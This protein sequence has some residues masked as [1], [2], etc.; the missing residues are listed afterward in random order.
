M[1]T[2]LAAGTETDPLISKSYTDGTYRTALKNSISTSLKETTKTPLARLDTLQDHVGYSFAEN[3]TRV[4]L[5]P[6]DTLSLKPGSSFMLTSGSAVI[7]YGSGTVINVSNGSIVRSGSTLTRNQRYMCMEGTIA[8]MKNERAAAGYVDSYYKITSS[9]ITLFVERLYTTVLKRPSDSS[10]LI[11]WIDQIKSGRMTPAQVASSFYASPE[12]LRQSVTDEDFV[13]RLYRSLLNRAPDSSGR[14]SW[15]NHLQ[16]GMTRNEVLGH[17]LNSPEF[18]KLCAGYN[19]THDST[20]PA[21]GT[22]VFITRLYA[23]VLNRQPDTSGYH[24]WLNHMQEG[25]TASTVAKSFVFSSE[26]IRRNLSDDQFLEMLYNSLLGRKSDS[27][28]K[29]NWLSH[30]Q[31]GMTRETVFNHFVSSSE[32]IKL[33]SVYDIER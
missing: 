2:V 13:E 32:F 1:V 31:N 29:R 26:S 17:F 7:M 23:D 22:R 10:G 20:K 19:L 16:A 14:R 8:H 5:I 27:S 21:M 11:N 12:F 24:N 30:M 4:R 6:H 9:Q 3:F 33:C 18:T 28:G 15:L 25:M